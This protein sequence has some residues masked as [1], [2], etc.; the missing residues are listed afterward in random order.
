[1]TTTLDDLRRVKFTTIKAFAQAWGISITTARMTLQG[2]RT[3]TM[4]MDEVYQIADVLDVTWA[5]AA[6]A[7]D[8]S[9]AA[10]YNDGATRVAEFR[11]EQHRYYRQQEADA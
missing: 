2:R 3:V 9:A 4:G 6:D 10:F 5:Q 1:M 7:L 11:W 8:A